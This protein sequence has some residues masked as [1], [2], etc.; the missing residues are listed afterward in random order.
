MWLFTSCPFL[1]PQTIEKHAF[2]WHLFI[3]IFSRLFLP[4]R[5][6]CTWRLLLIIILQQSTSL[7][8]WIWKPIVSTQETPS[9]SYCFCSV[10]RIRFRE[11]CCIISGRCHMWY[12]HMSPRI[13][14]ERIIQT[15]RDLQC[16]SSNGVE[17]PVVWF[18]C[19]NMAQNGKDILKSRF[20]LCCTTRDGQ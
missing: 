6:S 3:Q 18:K 7:I 20:S 11:N 4:V 19:S 16:S 17:S 5:F 9:K 10:L 13:D 15:V 8:L 14:Q 1:Q 2:W 12:W